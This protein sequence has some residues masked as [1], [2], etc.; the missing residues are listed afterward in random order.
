[1][2]WC[3]LNVND[4]CGEADVEN[5]RDGN[6]QVS[7]DTSWSARLKLNQVFLPKHD[8]TSTL[9]NNFMQE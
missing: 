8:A 7:A 9:T 3:L 1:M 4:K 5:S 2:N 6:A